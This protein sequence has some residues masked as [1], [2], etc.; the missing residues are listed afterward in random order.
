MGAFRRAEQVRLQPNHGAV[1]R[2]DQP[3]RRFVVGEPLNI[4]WKAETNFLAEPY[5]RSHAYETHDGLIVAMVS[6]FKGAD[7]KFK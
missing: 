4:Q 1:P 6:T 7:L 5:K 2:Q 3:E